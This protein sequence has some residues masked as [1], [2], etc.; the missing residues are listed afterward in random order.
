MNL[1]E[2][3]RESCRH[4]LTGVT[5]NVEEY[6]TMIHQSKRPGADYQINFAMKLG[7]ELGRPPGDVAQ[8]LVTKITKGVGVDEKVD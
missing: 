5:P 6:V 4:A 3:I 8:E 1:L 7:K 2:S